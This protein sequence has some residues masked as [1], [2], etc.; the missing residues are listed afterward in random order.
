MPYT[1]FLTLQSERNSEVW[2]VLSCGSA[3]YAVQRV[4]PWIK[5]LSVTFQMK[6]AEQYFPVVLFIVVHKVILAAIFGWNS[7]ILP[8]FYI[9]TF[10]G[11]FLLHFRRCFYFHL[12]LWLNI[13][14]KA[15]KQCLC[16]VLFRY[17]IFG[18]LVLNFG[19]MNLNLKRSWTTQ[20][21]SLSRPFL[22]YCVGNLTLYAFFLFEPDSAF[23]CHFYICR[24]EPLHSLVQSYFDFALL[25][26]TEVISTK[27]RFRS[28]RT[29]AV[30]LTV[31]LVRPYSVF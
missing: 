23:D 30:S 10:Y 20:I 14:V 29:R 31:T 16:G 5:S 8:S 19:S 21:K 13:H 4:L 3:H 6:A 24:E 27:V 1:V 11:A 25:S 22:W 9:H 12:L 15:A 18:A 17:C 26:L 7:S 2:L 28:L